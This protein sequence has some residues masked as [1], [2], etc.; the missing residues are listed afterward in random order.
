[1]GVVES[2]NLTGSEVSPVPEKVR[3]MYL[4]D[5]VANGGGFSYEINPG[6]LL[7]SGVWRSFVVTREEGGH[8]EVYASN[9]PLYGGEI[10][11]GVNEYRKGNGEAPLAHSQVVGSGEVHVAED[12]G[13]VK[14][15]N[16]GRFG[17]FDPG[18]G[19]ESI[20]KNEL[21]TMA[22]GAPEIQNG[23]WR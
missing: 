19:V 18:L 7:P 4:V 5:R 8:V 1:M 10:L 23:Y 12:R 14:V 9:G 17:N 16:G 13:L 20:I 2:E 11:R 22:R 21:G 3:Q 15:A 6:N